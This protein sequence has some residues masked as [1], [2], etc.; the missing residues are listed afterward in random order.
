MAGWLCGLRSCHSTRER[1]FKP[2]LLSASINPAEVFQHVTDQARRQPERWH[3]AALQNPGKR[4]TMAFLNV[5]MQRL[6]QLKLCQIRL[7]SNRFV[8]HWGNSRQISAFSLIYL[9]NLV[10]WFR[11]RHEELPTK[12]L[13][14]A[15]KGPVTLASKKHHFNVFPVIDGMEGSP[16]ESFSSSSTLMNYD[17]ADQNRN[18]NRIKEASVANWGGLLRL[19]GVSWLA[20]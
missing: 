18:Q 11:W 8:V 4:S 3:R 5:Q 19:T 10:T 2:H 7:L 17:A 9:S 15:T 12:L 1:G 20:R 16:R 6:V 14:C 13:H